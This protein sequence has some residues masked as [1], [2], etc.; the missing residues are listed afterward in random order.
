MFLKKLGNF[1][2]I[3]WIWEKK[4]GSKNAPKMDKVYKLQNGEKKE[5]ENTGT[6]VYMCAL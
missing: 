5:K 6:E 4:K 2:S 1:V 3:A